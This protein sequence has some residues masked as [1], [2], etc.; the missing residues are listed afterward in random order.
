MSRKAAAAVAAGLECLAADVDAEERRGDVAVAA[1][2]AVAAAVAGGYGPMDA[3]AVEDVGAG[4]VS[5]LS[6]SAEALPVPVAVV[7]SL[8]RALWDPS[9]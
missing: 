2:A 8:Q 3:S 6:S 1:A 7:A 5:A 9:A 4:V